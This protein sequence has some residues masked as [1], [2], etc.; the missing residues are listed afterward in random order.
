MSGN[1][2]MSLLLCHQGEH[3][4][5]RHRLSKDAETTFAILERW[6]SRGH[7]EKALH[8]SRQEGMELPDL[9]TPAAFLAC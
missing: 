8:T 1:D 4:I 3:A 9:L 7:W 6:M 2:V 5:S